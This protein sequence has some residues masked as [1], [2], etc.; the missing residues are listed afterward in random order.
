M[1]TQQLDPNSF[2]GLIN[3][4][5]AG[6]NALGKASF[7]LPAGFN[8][9]GGSVSWML[10]DKNGT[11]FAQ[12][13]ANDYLVSSTS[14]NTLVEAHADITA[15]SELPPTS[16][17][18][19]YQIRWTL[20][21]PSSP[22]PIY[23]FESVTVTGLT[24]AP[25]GAE[26]NIEMYGDPFAVGAV[27]PQV[28]A[29]A[30]FEM[31]DNLNRL[32]IPAGIIAVNT[33]VPVA[34]G[35]Y[36]TANID[37]NAILV[38]GANPL[39]AQLDPYVVS[40]K[41][42]KDPVKVQITRMTSEVYIVNPS[43][44]SAM[45]SCRSMVMKA[46]TTMFGMPDMIFDEA[47]MMGWLRRGRDMFNSAAGMLLEYTMTN[48]TGGI[49][50]YWLQYAEIAMLRAHALAEGEKAFNFAG[51]QITLDVEKSQYYTALADS[52]QAQLDQNIKPFKQNIL[53]KGSV[54]GD[55]NMNGLAG[56]AFG[57]VRLGISLHTASQYGRPNGPWGTY[58]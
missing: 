18:N 46:R 41:F 43:I 12:G 21:V 52:M 24:V 10:I 3:S 8:T 34:G 4:L 35:V 15:P 58:R 54:Q 22:T 38:T 49:R 27:L 44:L 1:A 39:I 2:N 40:W 13:N 29:T 26:T 48:A 53:K 16:E 30:Q 7:M 36:Y 11:M 37:P 45:E 51:A 56:S 14:F 55:G 57:A 19:S 32:L 42:K 33:P 5:I 17:G 25:E 50:E 28:Y 31:Y 20:N 47:T 9:A 6:D 23:S